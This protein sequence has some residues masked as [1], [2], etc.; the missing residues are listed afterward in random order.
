MGPGDGKLLCGPTTRIEGKER[1]DSKSCSTGPL[2]T[3]TTKAFLAASSSRKRPEEIMGWFL[4]IVINHPS[5]CVKERGWWV[6][7]PGALSVS[8]FRRQLAQGGVAQVRKATTSFFQSLKQE[9]ADS[10]C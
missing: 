7:A 5:P 10:Q 6:L 8:R 2:S 4:N 1:C 9:F 3:L